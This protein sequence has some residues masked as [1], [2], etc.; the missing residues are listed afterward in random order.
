M[1]EN[2]NKLERTTC[3]A[4]VNAKHTVLLFIVQLVLKTKYWSSVVIY[5]RYRQVLSFVNKFLGV[6]F[7]K[8]QSK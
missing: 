7:Q 4:K 3:K 1:H 8:H 5:F 2:Q 6:H